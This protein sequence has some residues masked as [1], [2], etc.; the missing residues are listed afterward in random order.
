M[1]RS[2]LRAVIFDMDGLMLDTESV[3]RFAWQRA[4]E[5]VGY[6]ISDALFASFIGRTATDSDAML[7][8]KW[9]ADFPSVLLRER[10]TYHWDSHTGEHGIAPKQGL[11]ELLDFLKAK[12]IRRAVAT[13][14]RRENAERKL[15]PYRN[16]FEVLVT[17]DDIARGK[18]APDIF[19]LAAKELGLGVEECLVLEDSLAGIR[20][21]KA[22]GIEAIMVPD[23]LA[24]TDEVGEVCASLD[25][26]R[27]WLERRLE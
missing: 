4:G 12:G 6:T 11:V 24:P 15:I 1:T 18:P 5:D 13:S 9:G 17:G 27:A 21:A 22:A 19:L 2:P 26:V 10:I 16:Y 3:A 7:R 20:A 14:S 8:E 25:E 23:L